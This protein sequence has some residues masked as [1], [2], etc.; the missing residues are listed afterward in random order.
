MIIQGASVY[1]KDHEFV[2]KDIITDGIV[3]GGL[4]RS[5]ASD[6]PKEDILEAEGLYAIPGLVDIHFH[7]AMGHD[8][9][10]GDL[11]G[12]M[13][14]ARY[15]A[16]NGILA[17]CPATMTNSEEILQGVMDPPKNMNDIV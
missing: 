10:D 15:E 16:A 17:I 14:I 5:S 9:C 12:L 3:I 7:G 13:E 2:Q 8:F 4:C 1:T 6:L 11:E